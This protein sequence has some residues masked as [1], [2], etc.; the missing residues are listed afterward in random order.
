MQGSFLRE[1]EGEFVAIIGSRDFPDISLV[2][3][4]VRGLARGSTV[5]SGGARGVDKAAENEARSA[6]FR[7]VVLKPNYS[8]GSPKAAPL[9]RNQKIADSCDRM[10]AF[11]DGSSRGTL[12]CIRCAELQNKPV[13]VVVLATVEGMSWGPNTI[14]LSCCEWRKRSSKGGNFMPENTA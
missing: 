5:I 1:V 12:H 11:W 3:N 13:L 14:A 7:V 6:G 9:L 2:S 8:S 10:V 4:L